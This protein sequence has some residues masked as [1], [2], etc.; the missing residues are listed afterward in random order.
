MTF[1][2]FQ[3][4]H[5]VSFAV[6][7]AAVASIN[8][9]AAWGETKITLISGDDWYVAKPFEDVLAQLRGEHPRAKGKVTAQTIS[10][11][12]TPRDMED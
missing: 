9:P 10:Y 12:V 3:D 5:G 6:N 4:I 1:H 2:V 8:T 11:E 7:D